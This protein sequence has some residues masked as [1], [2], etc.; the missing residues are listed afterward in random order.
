MQRQ[1]K[2][3]NE[4]VFFLTVKFKCTGIIFLQDCPGE[5]AKISSM[6]VSTFQPNTYYNKS[7]WLTETLT[8]TELT[9]HKMIFPGSPARPHPVLPQSRRAT[10]ATGVAGAS[11]HQT[12]PLQ[13]QIISISSSR[14]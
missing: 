3:L 12:W 2:T 6:L 13:D 9:N 7:Y 10:G 4:L 11:Q 14:Q 1:L 5:K 8:L